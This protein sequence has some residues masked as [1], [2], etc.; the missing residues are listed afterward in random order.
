VAAVTGTG[1][2]TKF[3][4]TAELVRIAHVTSTQQKIVFRIVRNI[5]V[6]NSGVIALLVSYALIH[7]MP[8]REMILWS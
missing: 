5:A 7:S 2:R 3:G 1:T 4:R 6:F 8:L